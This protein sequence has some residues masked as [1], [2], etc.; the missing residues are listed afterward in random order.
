[1]TAMT[2]ANR[3]TDP[4]A[5]QLYR[6][7][8]SYRELADT[9]TLEL[10]PLAGP[11]ATFAPGQFNMLYAFGIGEIAI[12]VSGNRTDQS[13]LIHTIRE[14]GAVSRAVAGLG[15]GEVVGLRGPFGV[16]WPVEAAA[17]SDVILVAGGLGLAPLR[18]AI[19]HLME[20]RGRYGRVTILFGAR[21]PHQLLFRHEIEQ[22]R[23]SLDVDIHVTVDHADAGWHGNVGVVPMLVPRVDLDPRETVAMVCGPEVMMRFTANALRSAGLSD[24][25]IYVSMERNMKCGIGLCGHCQFGPTFVCKDGPVM[26]YDRIAGIFAMREI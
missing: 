9:V 17:G 19:Y 5:S 18:P 24:D 14:V 1:M 8:R 26:R 12:S 16:G 4:F 20:N 11:C 7:A 13:K 3:G 23:E 25:R 15:V 2:P 6:V 21:D 22:W 10:T